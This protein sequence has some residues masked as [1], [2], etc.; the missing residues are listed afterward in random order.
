M[1]Q[2]LEVMASRLQLEPCPICEAPAAAVWSDNYFVATI[3]C[4]DPACRC[5]IQR[6]STQCGPAQ[7]L[8]DAAKAWN[9]RDDRP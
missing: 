3:I 7:I 6:G 5:K 2:R 8:R 4:L 9:K 1:I